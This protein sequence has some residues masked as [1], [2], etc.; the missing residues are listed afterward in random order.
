MGGDLGTAFYT[1]L[2]CRGRVMSDV[3]AKTEAQDS[4]RS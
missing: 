4:I 3:V 2:A 1:L